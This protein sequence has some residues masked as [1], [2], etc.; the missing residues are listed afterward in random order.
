MKASSSKKRPNKSLLIYVFFM[1]AVAIFFFDQTREGKLTVTSR[2][3]G[4]R[5]YVDKK[6]YGKTPLN[7]AANRGEHHIEVV[8]PGYAT[9]SRTIMVEAGKTASL[10][11]DLE[12]NAKHQ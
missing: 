1:V 12:Q 4:A 9:V 2:P 6:D 10:D 7:A 5:V 11:L 8:F 3:S